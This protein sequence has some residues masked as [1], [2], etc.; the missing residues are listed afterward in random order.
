MPRRSPPPIPPDEDPAGAPPGV[1]D[2]RPGPVEGLFQDLLRRAATIGFG[3][4]FLTEEAIRK[5]LADV[6]PPDW[7][8]F[9]VRQ[10]EEM[11]GELIDS[12]AQEFGS[13]MRKTDP[14]T[15]VRSVL[16]D[17]HFSIQINVSVQPRRE[18]EVED[19]PESAG[20]A[21]RGRPR[22]ERAG[23]GRMARNR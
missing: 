13:W 4:F 8:Q 19:T 5:A 16:D 20:K 11:R 14:E 21:D 9:V 17:Y 1:R 18:A 6:V 3:G 10:S 7:V 22:G 15:F 12:L 2:R 23:S